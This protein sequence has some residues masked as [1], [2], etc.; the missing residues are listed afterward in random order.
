M[1]AWDLAIHRGVTR[2]AV[3]G[4]P[5]ACSLPTRTVRTAR[6]VVYQGGSIPDGTAGSILS[7][8]RNR[9]YLI[10][11]FSESPQPAIANRQSAIPSTVGLSVV[12]SVIYNRQSS[13]YNPEGPRRGG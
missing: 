9:V 7:G 4:L 13:I 5:A 1:I 3:R 6:E 8:T 2:A 12:I 10:V 11:D